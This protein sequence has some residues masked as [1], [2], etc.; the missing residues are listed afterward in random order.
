VGVAL[1]VF[2]PVNGLALASRVFDPHNGVRQPFGLAG[3]AWLRAHA[4]KD[5]VLLVQHG[6]W[7]SAGL[8]ERDQYFSYGHPAAQLGY[9]RAEIDARSALEA[10]LFAT[11]HLAP[12]DRARLAAL[13]RPVYVVWVD[14]ADPRFRLTPGTMARAIAPAGPRPAFDA[15]L[16]V[17]FRSPEIEVR[18]VP[19]PSPE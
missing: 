4:P 10:R 16:P 6:D 12:E 2:L 7:E 8:A 15:D 3:F 5:A 1:L 19:L 14:F 11:G 13:R 17:V 18:S 9:D